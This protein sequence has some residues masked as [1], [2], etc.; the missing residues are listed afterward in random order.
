MREETQ[1][2]LHSRFN[3]LSLF[4]LKADFFLDTQLNR[5]VYYFLNKKKVVES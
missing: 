1:R 2:S 5:N 4:V 3:V